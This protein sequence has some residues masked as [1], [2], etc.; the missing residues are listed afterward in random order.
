MTIVLEYTHAHTH[1][2]ALPRFFNDSYLLVEIDELDQLFLQH[3]LP[4]HCLL[5]EDVLQQVGH[6]RS[7][8]K[9]LDET[10]AGSERRRSVRWREEGLSATGAFETEGS[11]SAA[12]SA[13]DGGVPLTHLQ[14]KSL[15]WS[16]Q[17]SGWWR[18]GGGFL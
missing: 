10:P 1:S 17:S 3:S 2:G 11:R 8:L 5:D 13:S 9:V 6:V 16:D 4:A 18:V 14:I 12:G 7:E 15:K